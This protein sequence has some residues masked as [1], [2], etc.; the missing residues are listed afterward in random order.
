MSASSATWFYHPPEKNLYL[1]GERVRGTFWDMRFG[2]LWL[3]AVSL[4]PTIILEGTHNGAHVKMEWEPAKWLRLSGAPTS[5]ALMRGL[6]TILR[7]KP[8]IRFDDAEG[9][10]VWEWWLEGAGRRWQEIQGKPAFHNPARLEM[11]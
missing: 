4:D 2:G 6:T 11:E 3:E 9:Y 5:P 8:A 7:R 10:T 1:L